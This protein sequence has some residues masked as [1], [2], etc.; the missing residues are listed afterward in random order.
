MTVAAAFLQSALDPAG[1]Q[2]AHIAR[3][4][5][6]LFWISAGVFVLVLAFLAAA[7]RHRG[8]QT[9]ERRLT[10]GVSLATTVTVVVLF[11]IL[12]VT[13]WTERVNATLGASSAVTIELTG[14]QFWWEVQYD[15]ANPS[16]RVT[17][18]NEMHIPVGRPVVLKVTS[19]D[20]IH[21]FWAPN[22]QGKRDLIPGYTTAIWLQADRPQTFR[23]QCAEFCGRQHAHMAMEVVAE[24]EAQYEQ[25]LA[26]RK[27]PAREPTDAG[28][29]R[30]REVFLT[31]QCV[32]CHRIRG[33]LAAGLV[34]P[35]LTHVASRGTLAAGTLPN[36][37]GHLAGWVV[38]PQ[39]LKPGS[40]MPDN[41]MTSEELQSLLAYLETL[42]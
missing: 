16:D 35:D 14:H 34:G 33:T 10:F 4:W 5:W 18:A 26:A 12:G 29:M 30:G 37:T 25:W 11:I 22:L 15:A 31:R 21:S 9:S 19:R 2:A 32:L 39:A 13:M 28:A 41:E 8:A 24:P 7:L 6:L 20:V 3:L 42:K 38:N 40:Q 27:A 23:A 17:T 1:P 36:T